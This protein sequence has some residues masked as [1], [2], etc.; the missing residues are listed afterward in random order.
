M[1]VSDHGDRGD[2]TCAYCFEE[3]PCRIASGNSLSGLTVWEA[4]DRLEGAL[5]RSLDKAAEIASIQATFDRHGVSIQIPKMCSGVML[6]LPELR[7]IALKLDQAL[8]VE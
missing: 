4:E 7:M 3:W 6:D 1:G 2:G 5:Q 8:P